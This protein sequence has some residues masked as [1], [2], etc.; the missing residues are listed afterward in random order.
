MTYQWKRCNEVMNV[1]LFCCFNNFVHIWLSQVVPIRY[2]LA[3]SSV[4]QDGFLL[5][6]AYCLSGICQAKHFQRYTILGLKT[7]IYQVYLGSPSKVGNCSRRRLIHNC[8]V[9][10]CVDCYLF[11]TI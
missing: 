8:R 10:L 5:Y 9:K 6:K 2:V 4:K 7:N 1:S 3:D 11:S